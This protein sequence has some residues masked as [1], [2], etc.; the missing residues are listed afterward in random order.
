MENIEN[1]GFNENENQKFWN[2]MFN[3]L[4]D[5]PGLNLVKLPENYEENL[6]KEQDEMRKIDPEYDIPLSYKWEKIQSKPSIL[7]ASPF[8]YG[9]SFAGKNFGDVFLQSGTRY[10]GKNVLFHDALNLFFGRKIIEKNITFGNSEKQFQFT[11]FSF[12]KDSVIAQNRDKYALAQNEIVA[13]FER[14]Q[15]RSNNLFMDVKFGSDFR[16]ILEDSGIS[17]PNELENKQVLIGFSDIP[18]HFN[19]EISNQQLFEFMLKK[20]GLDLQKLGAERVEKVRLRIGVFFDGTGN[21]KFNSDEA[22]YKQ[23][24]PIN[25]KKPPKVNVT[26]KDGKPF[27]AEANTSYWNAYTNITLLHDLYEEKTEKL[28]GDNFRTL[29]LKQYVEGIGTKEKEPDDMIGAALGEGKMGVID[30]VKESCEDITKKITNHFISIQSLPENKKQKIR[31]EIEEIKFDVFGFSRGAAAARHF[32]NEVLK[33]KSLPEKINDQQ[34]KA[35]LKN[36]AKPQKQKKYNEK[37]VADQLIVE[38]KKNQVLQPEHTGSYLEELFDRV[39]HTDYPIDHVSVEFLGLFDTVI[40]QMLEKKGIIDAAHNFYDFLDVLEKKIDDSFILNAIEN[41]KTPLTGLSIQQIIDLISTG[42]KEIKDIPKVNPSLK[43]TKIKKVFHILAQNDWR[44]NFPVTQVTDA[45]D[46]KQ[47]WMLGAHSDIGGG[48]ASAIVEENIL[49]FMDV[50]VKAKPDQ[51]TKLEKERTDL[52]NWYINQLFCKPEELEWIETH[53]ISETDIHFPISEFSERQKEFMRDQLQKVEGDIIYKLEAKHYKLVSTRK[54]NNKLSLVPF[55]VMQHMAMQFGNVPFANSIKELK[56]P[57]P[58]PEEYILPKELS[59]YLENMKKIAE[60]G[61]KKY[62]DGSMVNYEYL[63]SDF[64]KKIY[65]IDTK[66]Y[67]L[68]A[69]KFIH[70]SA[71]YNG[72]PKFLEFLDHKPFVYTNVP[73]FNPNIAERDKQPY[74]RSSY[75]P[76]LTLQDKVRSH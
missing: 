7:A 32:C 10:T 71:N 20:L 21:N 31:F 15:N 3:N 42:A 72:V 66:T 27:E 58:H 68:I 33:R 29:Q 37:K 60:S 17:N 48:Y 55:Y 41:V 35:D 11:G 49:H 19:T 1:E 76:Q 47:M 54:L 44:E 63:F 16:K 5:I 4:E 38:K 74:Q 9:K 51:I 26:P 45:Y 43:N 62:N 6:K 61:W 69:N 64:A 23:E 13:F 67:E 75:T 25:D 40:S 70:L 50:S 12:A 65:E 24:L 52:R 34:N 57:V 18:S 8:I 2:E 36:A 73:Q 30:R 46:S 53:H 39:L 59:D 56:H 14:N 28:R 22:Y